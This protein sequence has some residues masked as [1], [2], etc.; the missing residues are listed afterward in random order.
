MTPI[1]INL[2]VFPSFPFNF[3]FFFRV[4]YVQDQMNY[5]DKELQINSGTHALNPIPERIWYNLAYLG[6]KAF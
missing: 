5:P 6:L 4:V 2:N 1:Q 3:L